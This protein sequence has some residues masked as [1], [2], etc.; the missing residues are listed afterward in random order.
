M[1][2]QGTKADETAG[3]RLLGRGIAAATVAAAIVAATLWIPLAEVRAAVPTPGPTSS[4][5]TVNAGGVRDTATSVAGLAGVTLQLYNG[6]AAGPTTPVA[7]SWATCVSDADGDCSFVVPGTNLTGPNRDRR[8]WVVQTGAAPDYEITTTLGT[9]DNGEVSTPY[10]FRT[11]TVLRSGETYS[12]TSS[13]MIGTGDTNSVASGGI[14]ATTRDNPAIPAQCGLTVALV[15]DLSGSTAGSFDALKTAAQEMVDALA[16]TNSQIALFTFATTAPAAPGANLP[17]TPVSTAAGAAT[18]NAAI[19]ALPTPV[20]GT[21]WDRGLYQVAASTTGFDTAVVVT[22]GN[23]TFYGNGEGPGFFTRFREVENGI[24]SSNTVKSQGTNVTVL[25]VGAGLTGP[26]DNLAAISGPVQGVDY[27]RETDYSAAAAAFRALA[28]AGCAGSVTV[29]KNVIPSTNAAGDVSNAT[30][31]GGWT[32]DA[33]VS[34]PPGTVAPASGQTAD[35]TGAL[36]FALTDNTDAT[37]LQLVETVQPGFSIEQVDGANAVC[38]DLNTQASVAVDN[39]T[40]GFSLPVPPNAAITCQVYNRSPAS[41]ATVVVDKE[42]VINGGDP[43]PE[44]NQLEGLQASLELDATTTPWGVTVSGYTE[45]ATLE[46]GESTTVDLDLCE[47]TSSTLTGTGVIGSVPLDP[48]ASVEL[49]AGEND[50]VVR[51]IVECASRL[52][53]VKATNGGAAD[54]TAWDLAASGPSGSL[55]GPSG[56][57]GSSSATAEVSPAVRYELAESGGDPRYV[58]YLN[59]EAAAGTTASWDCV[60]LD[61]SGGVVPGYA[62]GLNGGVTVPYGL[63]VRCTALNQ[64]SSLILVK[65]VVNDSGGQAVPA[66]WTL[67]AELVS[68]IPGIDPLAVPGSAEGTEV[69]VRP[70]TDYRVS[71]TG[72][73]PATDAYGLES[74]TC[75]DAAGEPANLVSFDE[76]SVV[77]NIPA[78]T[79]MVCTFVNTDVPGTWRTSKSSDPVTG[80]TVRVG[81]LVTYTVQ[82]VHTGG[83]P[84]PDALVVDDL[85]AVL[86]H[87]EIVTQPV[88]TAGAVTRVGDRLEWLIPS[89]DATQTMT[90]S[91]RVTTTQPNVEILNV[92][93][94]SAGG[95]CD[96]ACTSVVRTPGTPTP[97]EPGAGG[98]RL[99]P[100]TGSAPVPYFAVMLVI[101]VVG[102]ALVLEARRQRSQI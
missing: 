102:V 14:W 92:L 43:V 19:D 48:T 55:P 21:N 23:P 57:S 98:G 26:P 65:E 30:P 46:V 47:I 59:P 25:G 1:A 9:G 71:E 13:F 64:I 20:G 77:V 82:A 58:P 72:S 74:L 22:D 35:V 44:G 101:M 10:R 38:T 40:E 90:F 28:L 69:A 4:V 67:R 87:A 68:P 34:T 97:P 95:P 7:D 5:I 60:Q 75:V 27:F 24:F 3:R 52:T 79:T 8:F 86:P 41:A 45:G 93:Q 94:Q 56:A 96:D 29:V 88:V 83:G 84:V 70:G 33:T 78:D 63:I 6:G 32:F 16:G 36:S 39:V 49:A 85:S 51:N 62:D 61:E 42:W 99:L 11:G 18:V 73:S 50:F 37:R 81:D 76:V 15:L 17:V 2:H 54:V 31:A 91:V 89:L 100:T 53:L 66:D 80:S 12:S